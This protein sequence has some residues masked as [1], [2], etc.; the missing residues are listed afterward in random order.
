MWLT[1]RRDRLN[2]IIIFVLIAFLL[3]AGAKIIRKNFAGSSLNPKINPDQLNHYQIDAR[4]DPVK[5]ILEGQLKLTY[6]NRGNK[7]N[8][9]L[10]FH[11]FPNAFSD[12]ESAPCSK[13]YLMVFYPDGFSPGYLEIEQVSLLDSRQPITYKLEGIN[14]W[15]DLN[16]PLPPEGTIKLVINFKEQIPTAISRFGGYQDLF[17]L[18]NWYPV[19]AV[20]SDGKWQP[21]QYLP[22]GDPFFSETAAYTVNFTVPQGYQIAH[23]GRLL[24]IENEENWQTYRM[25]AQPV[26]DFA[27][28]LGTE[29]QVKSE[30]LG[31]TKV[32]SY[33]LAGAEVYGLEAARISG[34][35]LEFFSQKFGQ[36]PY[37]VFTVVQAN[38][39]NGGMEYP[40]L[41]MIGKNLYT[42]S[43]YQTKV[44]EFVL[45]HEIAH[46][47]WYGLVGNDQFNEPWLD[48]GLANY[49]TLLYFEQLYGK[50]QAET[51]K[52]RFLELPSEESGSIKLDQP[53][54]AYREAANYYA[55]VYS[56][57]SLAFAELHE[58]LGDRTFYQVLKSYVKNYQYGYC[59]ID[60]FLKLAEKESRVN[61]DV[62]RKKY[63]KK[64]D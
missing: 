10:L 16:Q 28:S 43:Y 45:V 49:S 44:F 50:K 30:Q 8:K 40:Q 7:E 17:C 58:L 54:T 15:L 42:E 39:L 24:G 55:N 27:L 25:K 12:S 33:Y 5:M 37:S 29:Y 52:K 14:L 20:N 9:Q 56:R 46:Q 6:T 38:L 13:E 1:V 23:T 59:T 48:E 63:L 41:V 62:F 4:L 26:R 60:G 34:K 2:K 61:L 47:W 64:S 19:L 22:W 11:V 36:Y 31:K 35:A 51:I 3:V 57:G 32:S 53:L 21:L 18:G